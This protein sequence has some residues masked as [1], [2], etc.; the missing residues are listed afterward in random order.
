VLRLAP[1][2]ALAIGTIAL[3]AA[4]AQVTPPPEPPRTTAKKEQKKPPSGPPL[5]AF[6]PSEIALPVEY[7]AKWRTDAYAPYLLPKDGLVAP[8]GGFDVMFHFHGGHVS[9][10]EWR[11]TGLNAAI[12]VI[13]LGQGSGIYSEAFAD[14]DRLGRI[15][16]E[17]TQNVGRITRRGVHVRRVGLL[18]WSAGYGATQRILTQSRYDSLVDAV[19]LL[20]GLHADYADRRT[21]KVDVRMIDPFIRFAREAT[22]GQKQMVITFSSIE[23]TGY[24]SSREVTLSLLDAVGV[25]PQTR[26]QLAWKGMRMILEA[27]EGELWVRGFAGEDTMDHTEHLQLTE[28]MVRRHIVTRWTRLAKADKEKYKGR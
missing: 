28:E 16:D 14:P 20:D 7:E 24:A 1:L 5:E 26:D 12:V 9:D 6:D 27:H 23:T 11:N 15:L 4:C 10:T 3:V 25:E 8:D 17:L 18:S 21:H 19:V 22:K 2:R 13:T